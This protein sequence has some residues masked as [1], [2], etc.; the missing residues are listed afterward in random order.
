MNDTIRLDTDLTS[1]QLVAYLGETD[2]EFLTAPSPSLAKLRAEIRLRLIV[3][4]HQ[5]QER[6]YLLTLNVRPVFC[7]TR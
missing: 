3:M 2:Q 1:Q 7:N 6:I 4:S 5:K